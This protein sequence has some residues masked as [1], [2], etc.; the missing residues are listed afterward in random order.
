M[1]S[2]PELPE[3]YYLTHFKEFLAEIHEASHLLRE[4]EKGFL[5]EFLSLSEDAQCLYVRMVNRKGRIFQRRDFSYQEIGDIDEGLRELEQRNFARGPGPSDSSTVISSLKKHEI[6]DLLLAARVPVKKSASKPVLLEL[7][8]DSG[9]A[10][11]DELSAQVLIQERTTELSYLLFLYFGKILEG[12]SLYT[13][14]DLGIKR[15]NKY[16]GK[17]KPR[18]RDLEDAEAHFFYALLAEDVSAAPAISTWPSPKNP[19]ATDLRNRVLLT[20]AEATL[21][22]EERLR[23]LSASGVHPAREKLVRALWK[24]G[25]KEECEETLRRIID[26]PWEEEEALFAEDFL[27][28]KFGKKRTSALTDVLRSSELLRIDESYFRSPELGVIDALRD[29]GWEAWHTENHFWNLFFGLLFWE[30]IFCDPKAGF[31][32]SFEL[33]PADLLN[34]TFFDNHAL[35]LSNK[36]DA[37][38]DPEWTRGYL[39]SIATRYAEDMLGIFSW[40]EDSLGLLLDALPLIPTTAQRSILETMARSY[41]QFSAGF[42][43]LIAR[44]KG[45]IRFIEVKAKGDSLKHSQLKI[46]NLLRGAGLPVEVLRVEYFYNPEQTYTVVDLETTGA[47]AE[48]DRITEI[49]AVKIR[50]GVILDRYQTLV[51]PGRSIPRFIQELTGITNAMVAEAPRFEDVAEAFREFSEGSIFVAHNVNFD[52]RFL[53]KEFERTGEKFVRPFLCTKAGMKKCYPRL[54]SYSL[55]ELTARFEIPLLNHHRA[56]SDAEA[57]AGLL[58]LINEKR[59]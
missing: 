42:P 8:R 56:L 13:L 29:E 3:K 31:R 30:E 1:N 55:K 38:A 6:L 43:D 25:R 28:R 15:M 4:A 33:L 39:E 26:Q 23:L 58:N 2:R 36:L 54:E 40:D 12:L 19:E 20:L 22:E 37:L 32:N 57:A 50:G 7:V 16:Q 59:F 45:E 49:G 17:F 24:L 5:S 14:R 53:Q 35:S 46:I 27:D 18:F 52:Y 34:G 51:N 9:L 21:D 10:L 47:R 11:S 44:R 41:P 48:W